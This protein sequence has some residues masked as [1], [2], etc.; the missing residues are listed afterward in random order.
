MA[1]KKLIDTEDILEAARLNGFAGES[2]ARVMMLLLR[3]R[4]INKLY[5]QN[6]DKEGID[7]ID[8][9]ITQLR[10]NYEVIPQEVLRIPR[11]GP[12]IIVCN[13][14]YGGIDGMLLIKIVSGIRDDFR[15]MPDFL[16]ERIGPLRQHIFTGNPFLTADRGKSGSA[17]AYVKQVL[18]HLENGGGLGIF[19]AGEISSYTQPSNVISDPQWIYPV[20]KMIKKAKVP[21]I[22]V[23]FQ[24][25]NS[26][27]FH[28]LGLIHPTLKAVKLPSELFN[29]KK[30]TVRIRIGNPIPVKEQNDFADISRYGRF[31]RSKAYALGS[32]LE[33]KK[34]YSFRMRRLKKASPVIEP[35]DPEKIRD[36]IQRI[37]PENQ[38]FKNMNY[39]IYCVPSV[40]I[41]NIM[42]ELGRLRE[43]T[44]R[45]I[46]E[47]TNQSMDID[48]FDLYYHQL[49][50]WDEERQQIV[51]AYR[52]GKGKEIM[53]QYGIRGFYIHTLFRI[54]K[55]FFPVLRQSLELGRSFIVSEYQKKPMPLFLLWKGI[56]YFLLKN[57]E[58]RYL[59]GPVSISSR[60]SN[61]S[62]GVIIGFII[63]NYL[64]KGFARYI[65]PRKKFR[66][67][68]SNIDTELLFGPDGDINKLD[69][70]LKD[71]EVSNINMPVLLKKYLKQNGKII[72]FNV[73]PK[74]N[75]ALDGLMILDLY[76]VPPETISALS[77]EVNDESI[78]DRFTYSNIYKTDTPAA[79]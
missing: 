67:R 16:L 38:L 19:P 77:R 59:I 41:P 50:V 79:S 32:S 11:Q 44:F 9:M 53:E 8:S 25:R 61:F 33:V 39:R 73:D 30:R 64:H 70:L 75:N 21:V 29:K 69:R 28:I 43:I 34:F 58:Y 51:G 78:L 14:P 4:R 47:G 65:R 60:F 17:L 52:I 57:P 22:P 62:R 5:A 63:R 35:I 20:V 74:F 1:E 3:F 10:I 40:D 49:F 12:F 37:K 36:E 23:F 31:L 68:D 54:N 13:H 2:A 66:V 45:E 26:K 76:D 6:L 71:I 46:G 55:R 48:E 72:G 27:L 15:S 24:G 7:F 18:Q 42:N 56:L